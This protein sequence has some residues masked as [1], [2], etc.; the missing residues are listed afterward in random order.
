LI[1]VRERERGGETVTLQ[2]YIAPPTEVS[3]ATRGGRKF[4]SRYRS[5]HGMVRRFTGKHGMMGG[6]IA[7][8]G[9]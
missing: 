7:C 9:W 8:K 1:R 6:D 4:T 2:I 3:G 5:Q